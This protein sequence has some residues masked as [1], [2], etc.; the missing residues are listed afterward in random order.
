MF[1]IIFS[2]KTSI[3][4]I[5]GEYSFLLF[6]WSQNWYESIK[7]IFFLSKPFFVLFQEQKRV[8]QVEY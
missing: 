5:I 1:S 3:C 8:L 7:T 4:R 6:F 2:D